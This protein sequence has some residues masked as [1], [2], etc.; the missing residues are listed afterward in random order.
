MLC[1]GR[2]ASHNFHLAMN[3]GVF[4]SGL[5]GLTVLKALTAALPQYNYVYLG[6][7]ARNPYG[8]RSKETITTYVKEAVEFF[9][10]EQQ[11]ELVIFACNT[12]SAD[13][14]RV[15]QQEYL[16]T[17]ASDTKR[18][19]GVLIPTAELAASV[20]RYGRIGV[21]A[22]R[23]TVNSGAYIRE[24]TKA[25]PDLAITQKATP[26]LVPLIEE[27]WAAK[28]ETN[29]ILKKYLRSLKDAHV[30]TLIL[31]CTHYPILE[32]SIRRI[33]GKNVRLITSAEATA[34]SLADYLARH[35]ELESL[36]AKEGKVT[37]FTTD[38]PARFLELGKRVFHGGM[39]SVTQVELGQ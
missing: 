17:F 37:Y 8:T 32:R 19:L 11:C 20:T 5:G 1:V 38:D 2:Q 9:F 33:M 10:R 25:R 21:I 29:S 4:D 7:T 15:V 28:P 34:A 6:D 23:G 22:T 27:G 35:T 14:L 31:G 30:D 16:P 18:V 39:G 12:A 26:L 3:I 36:L 13:A 24:L